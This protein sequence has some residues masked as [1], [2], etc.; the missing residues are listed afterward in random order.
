MR[1]GCTVVGLD[2][3]VPVETILGVRG[4]GCCDFCGLALVGQEYVSF[5][6]REFC[7]TTGQMHVRFE[8]GWA[9]CQVCAPMVSVKAW[10][11]LSTRVLRVA[12]LHGG[13]VKPGSPQMSMLRSNLVALWMDL[14][15]HGLTGPTP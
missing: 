10:R 7:R 5:T 1:C 15:R 6:A 13:A 8:P 14:D 3:A 11:R 2:T 9:A 4:D 12:H